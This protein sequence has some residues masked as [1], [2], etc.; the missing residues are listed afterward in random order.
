[1]DVDDSFYKIEIKDVIKIPLI[2]WIMAIIFGTI[3]STLV[4]ISNNM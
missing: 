3:K 4:I 2:F 1:M